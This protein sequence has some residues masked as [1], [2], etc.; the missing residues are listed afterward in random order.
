MLMAIVLNLFQVKNRSPTQR[1]PAYPDAIAQESLFLLQA[2]G[3][4]RVTP[5]GA[6]C[7]V[8]LL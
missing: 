5:S 1:P 6:K 3:K 2:R 4:N 8:P 7:Q